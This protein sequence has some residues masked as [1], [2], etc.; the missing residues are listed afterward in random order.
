LIALREAVLAAGGSAEIVVSDLSDDR[1]AEKPSLSLPRIDIL[2]N[3]AGGRDRRRIE[4]LDRQAVRDLVEVN[5]V[6]P[7]DLARSLSAMMLAGGRIINI[8]SIAGQIARSGDAAYTM[9]KSGL[10][11]LTRGAGRR[12]GR[13]TDYSERGCAGLLRH[14]RERVHGRGRCHR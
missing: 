5:L 10:D 6:A 11:G 14:G 8:T 7:F 1:S 12:V 13:E 9:T 3:N 2:I 4:E